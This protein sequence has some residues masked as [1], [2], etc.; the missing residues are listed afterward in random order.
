MEEVPVRVAVR[1]GLTLIHTA[2][3]A[4]SALERPS[5]PLPP[6]KSSKIHIIPGGI[7]L[8][9]FCSSYALKFIWKLAANIFLTFNFASSGSRHTAQLYALQSHH[10]DQ[11]VN[12]PKL[13]KVT[14]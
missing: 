9:T 14:G 11:P 8:Q 2:R 12:F 7:P 6:L 1:V 4:A 10:L 13:G 5:L 3:F